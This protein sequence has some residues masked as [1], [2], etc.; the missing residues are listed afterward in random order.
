MKVLG[1]RFS[2]EASEQKKFQGV[3]NKKNKVSGFTNL[4]HKTV[5][6][7]E[8]IPDGTTGASSS[9]DLLTGQGDGETRV[10][11]GDED[12]SLQRKIHSEEQAEEQERRHLQPQQQRGR[13]VMLK[14]E[15]L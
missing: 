13:E 3:L 2:S 11:A 15:Q 14:G 12:R 8:D 7:S 5:R 10:R 4:Q 6:C 9:S 1:E